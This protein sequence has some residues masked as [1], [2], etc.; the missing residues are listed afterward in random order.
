MY[1]RL[2]GSEN[3]PV[4]EECVVYVS[5]IGRKENSKQGN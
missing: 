2:Y 3:S 4:T 5:Y 1:L